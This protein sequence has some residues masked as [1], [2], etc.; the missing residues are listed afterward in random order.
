MQ[1]TRTKKGKTSFPGF[2][3]TRIQIS[4]IRNVRL[5]SIFSILL[6]PDSPRWRFV[7]QTEISG[8]YNSPFYFCLR[9]LFFLS[10]ILA[11]SIFCS[12]TCKRE[13]LSSKVALA[14]FSLVFAPCQTRAFPLPRQGRLRARE[15]NASA[16]ENLPTREKATRG[17]G[18]FHA[19]SRFARSA[20]PEEKWGTTRSL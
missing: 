12:K 4:Q 10:L 16:R 20:I 5:A 9:S 3:P 15:R 1:I 14:L 2:S 11:I 18:D 19:R 17:E 8:K 13:Y 6:Q 7:L